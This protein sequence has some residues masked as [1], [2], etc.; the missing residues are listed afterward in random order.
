[1][2][3]QRT[4]EREA[5][6]TVVTAPQRV[7]FAPGPDHPVVVRVG[8]ELPHPLERGVVLWAEGDGRVAGVSG[9]CAKS[10]DEANGKAKQIVIQVKSGHVKSGDVRDLKGTIEREKAAMG[11]LITLEDYFD[12]VETWRERGLK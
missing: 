2:S 8:R 12:L 11:V 3:G 7:R 5:L 9:G 1:M 6:A 10:R 4:V